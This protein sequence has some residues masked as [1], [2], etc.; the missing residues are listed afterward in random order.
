MID[1]YEMLIVTVC[2]SLSLSSSLTGHNTFTYL[3]LLKALAKVKLSF[4]EQGIFL[5]KKPCII[6]LASLLLLLG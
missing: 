1:V 5:I 6:N 2:F 3:S 4:L